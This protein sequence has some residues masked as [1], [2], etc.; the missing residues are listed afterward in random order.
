V[1]EKEGVQGM[2]WEIISCV[3]GGRMIQSVTAFTFLFTQAVCV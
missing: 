2:V 3:H 1:K